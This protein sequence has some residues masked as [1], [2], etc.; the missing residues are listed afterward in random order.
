MIMRFKSFLLL[1]RLMLALGESDK[2]EDVNSEVTKAHSV[3]IEA[4]TG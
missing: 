4:G 1:L 2:V 3:V